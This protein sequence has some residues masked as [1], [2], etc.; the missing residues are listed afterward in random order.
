MGSL[1]SSLPESSLSSLRSHRCSRFV[2]AP[3][4]GGIGNGLAAF[5]ASRIIVFIVEQ[6]SLLSIRDCPLMGELKMG[7]LPSSFPE[8]SLSSSKSHRCSRFA[9]ATPYGGTENGLAAF[10]VSRIIVFIV[11]R[12]SRAQK[13][14]FFKIKKECGVPHA[15]SFCQK[16]V[17]FLRPL[18]Q[19]SPTF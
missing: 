13:F 17:C 4:C 6:S 8:S 5:I 7:S 2:T 3:L 14:F 12:A 15:C 11:A 18:M 16:H 9:T 1:P 19:R 10:I